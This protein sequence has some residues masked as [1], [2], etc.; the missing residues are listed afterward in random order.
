M[1]ICEKCKLKEENEALKMEIAG[2][3]AAIKMIRKSATE[4][5]KTA[6]WVR[7]VPDYCSNCG[8]NAIITKETSNTVQWEL[9]PYCAYC[10]FEMVNHKEIFNKSYINKK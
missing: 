1:N 5:K 7:G 3:E 4:N 10:G 8:R 2:M 9:T 6:E